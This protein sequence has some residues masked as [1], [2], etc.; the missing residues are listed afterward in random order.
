MNQSTAS[1][2]REACQW[3]KANDHKLLRG[4][5]WFDFTTTP[6]GC[7]AIGALLLQQGLVP[8]IPEDLS[9]SGFTSL[10][11]EALGEDTFWLRRFWMGWDRGH[12][13]TLIKV[14]K[15]KKDVETKDDVSAFAITLWKEMHR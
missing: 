11:C 9:N 14:E 4:G 7:D 1:R 6:W 5:A 13:A 12:V 3:A 2:I 10:A 15:D 8:T